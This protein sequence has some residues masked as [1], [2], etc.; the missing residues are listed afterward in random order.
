LSQK[1]Y[2]YFYYCKAR[3]AFLFYSLLIIPGYCSNSVLFYIIIIVLLSQKGHNLILSYFNYYIY[4]LFCLVIR[5]TQFL[6]FINYYIFLFMWFIFTSFIVSGCA[7]SAFWL[8]LLLYTF[9]TCWAKR[10][11]I[12]LFYHYIIFYTIFTFELPLFII[13]LPI[14]LRFKCTHLH[15]TTLHSSLVIARR[16]QP[17][18][19]ELYTIYTNLQRSVGVYNTY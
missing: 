11:V 7:E 1:G 5:A 18:L 8:G 17:I 15:T 2:I 16:T 4:I 10:A 14:R 12:C 19:V 13:E 3:R 9:F 6:A